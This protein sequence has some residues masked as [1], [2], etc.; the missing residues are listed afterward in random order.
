[1]SRFQSFRSLFL[2][3]LLCG[4]FAGGAA[5]ESVGGPTPPSDLIEADAD[6]TSHSAL[7]AHS[8]TSVATVVEMDLR[9]VRVAKVVSIPRVQRSRP[10]GPGFWFARTTASASAD[11]AAH[12]RLLRGGIHSSSLGTPPPQS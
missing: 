6:G 3:A 12:A 9:G 5:A 1:M 10:E 8:L 4:A 2:A 11:I 7:P